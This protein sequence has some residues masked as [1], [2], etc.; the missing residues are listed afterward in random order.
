MP[1]RPHPAD[2][3]QVSITHPS[4][5]VTLCAVAGEIDQFTADRFRRELIGCLDTAAPTVV[6]DLSNVTFFGVAGLRVLMEAR[7][8]TGH[9]RRRLRLVAG[10]SCVDR[11]FEVARTA[12][13]FEL[14]PDLAT[15]VLDD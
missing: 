14:V 8:W 6:V 2:R 3:L 13:D 11:V 1:Q 12:A 7:D 5:S 9:T 10:T 4:K 15:A